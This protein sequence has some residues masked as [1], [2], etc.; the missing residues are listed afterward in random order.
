MPGFLIPFLIAGTILVPLGIL[1]WLGARERRRF[2][3]TCDNDLGDLKVFK[4]YWEASAPQLVGPQPL[5]ISGVG[6]NTGPTPSQKSTAGF[7]ESQC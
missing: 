6:R 7:R 2:L 3:P 1:L 4:N 5:S